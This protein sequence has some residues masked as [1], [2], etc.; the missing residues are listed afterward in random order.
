MNRNRSALALGYMLVMLLLILDA[1]TA[2]IGAKE[3][4]SLCLYTVIPSLFPLFVISLLLNSA[5]IG[6]H[7]PFF[8]H[9]SNLCGIPSGAESLLVLGILGGYPVGAQCVSQCYSE[10]KI[11]K[12]SAA[13][14]LGFCSNAGPSFI[15]GMCTSLFRDPATVWYLWFIHI[16]SAIITGMLIP[17]KQRSEEVKMTSKLLT[18]GDALKQT[19]SIL[20]GVCSWIILFRVLICILSRWLCPLFS[21]DIL[22]IFGGVLELS[23]G[24]IALHRIDD[25]AVRFVLMSAFLAFGGICVLMQTVTAVKSLGLGMYIPG[26]LLQTALSL[27]LSTA[28]ATFLFKASSF[29]STFRSICIAASCSILLLIFTYFILFKKYVAFVEKMRYNQKKELTRFSYAVQKKDPPFLQLLQ[30][31]HKS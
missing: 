2:I 8:R 7:I 12:N 24:C 18:L 17:G 28:A 22:T 11:T 19:A 10:R 27:L 29:F 15:F 31:R 23:N 26:K 21:N 25:E 6:I 16:L 20:A 3:G 13:R 9:L 1:K 4:I 30:I 5:I 14:M